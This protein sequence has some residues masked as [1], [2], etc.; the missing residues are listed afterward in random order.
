MGR[1]DT[2]SWDAQ[3][4]GR[5]QHW[6]SARDIVIEK[7][8]RKDNYR[9]TEYKRYYRHRGSSAKPERGSH[10]G[11]ICAKIGRITPKSQKISL[12]SMVKHQQQI[13]HN[14]KIHDFLFQTKLIISSPSLSSLASNKRNNSRN[15]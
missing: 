7:M 9:K 11:S 8:P 6:R 15:E 10:A 5:R 12:R 13:Q 1:N 2:G 3:A 14:V 4:T